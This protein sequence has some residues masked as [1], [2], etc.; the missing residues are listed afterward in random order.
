MCCKHPHTARFRITYQLYLSI[1]YLSATTILRDNLEWSRIPCS[2]RAVLISFPVRHSP[3]HPRR[4][5]GPPCNTYTSSTV[6]S[7]TS[8][9]KYFVKPSPRQ[10]KCICF[11]GNK[12]PCSCFARIFLRYVPRI[13]TTTVSSTGTSE[14]SWFKLAIRLGLGKAARVCGVNLL[15]TR[16]AP[17]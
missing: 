8:S 4:A 12:N 6:G 14:A 16:Y 3:H 1:F 15:V 13:T 11:L 7:S 10:P 17:R 5:Q 9:S 2:S